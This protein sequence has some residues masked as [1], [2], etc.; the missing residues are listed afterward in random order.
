MKN[1]TKITSALRA[2]LVCGLFLSTSFLRAQP[3]CAVTIN[4]NLGCNVQLDISFIEVPGSC[5]NCAGNPINITIPANSSTPI[6]CSSG[7]F[8]CINT[9]CDLSAKFT[10]P[11]TAGPFFYNTGAQTLSGLGGNCAATVNAYIIIT[12]TTID[13]NP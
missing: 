9:L 7:V 8:G 12:A 10:S 1:T 13:I 4:N 6:L 5:A 3:N 2:L 11:I